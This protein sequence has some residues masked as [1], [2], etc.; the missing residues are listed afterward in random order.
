MCECY[1][2][3][4]AQFTFSPKTGLF[5]FHVDR[6]I[7][8]LASALTIAINPGYLCHQAMVNALARVNIARSR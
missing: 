8:T 6:A 7:L 3:Q 4:L 1:G 2:K 5:A